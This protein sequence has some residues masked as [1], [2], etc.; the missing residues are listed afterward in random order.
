MKNFSGVY[1]PDE[2]INT[3]E[4]WY[5]GSGFYIRLSNDEIFVLKGMGCV[6]KNLQLNSGWEFLP[7]LSPCTIP[8]VEIADQ[9]SGALTVIKEISGNRAYWPAVGVT[10]LEE[11]EPGR[12]YLILL[13]NSATVIFPD[14]EKQTKFS[15]DFGISETQQSA[16]HYAKTPFTHLICVEY[17]GEISHVNG[18][19]ICVFNTEGKCCGYSAI[20]ENRGNIVV[21]AFGDD[22]T[23]PAVDGMIEGEE[24]F[25]SLLAA[26]GNILDL[27]QLN[28]D[29]NLPDKNIFAING[30]S[31]IQGFKTGLASQSGGAG[32][33][34]MIFPNPAYDYL[35]IEGIHSTAALEIS[36]AGGKSVLKQ[37]INSKTRIDLSDLRS[38][39]YFLR[40]TCESV[41]ISEKIV[42]R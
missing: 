27:Q 40:I 42:V 26:D 5:G 39:L 1:W 6:N 36:N 34:I 33:G 37:E 11:L 25:F 18:K 28:F 15:G 35:I 7:V 19:A 22:P 4:Y 10:T 38:G 41:T 20:Q 17:P 23:T 9:L 16:F 29:E 24:M 12:A 14:C 8:V 21:T 3:L 32:N 2:E 31:K 30:L 13:S